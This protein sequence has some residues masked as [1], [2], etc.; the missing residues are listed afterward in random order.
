MNDD[1]RLRERFAF[2]RR[3]EAASTPSFERVLGRARRRTHDA[4]WKVGVA[5]ALVMLT[6]TVI[7]VRMTPPRE[8]PT[9][10]ASHLMLADWRAATDFLLDTPGRELLHTIPDVGR[11]FSTGL[12]PLPPTRM[13]T[14]APRAGREHS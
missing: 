1:S 14:P 9:I 8:S 11:N 2:L 6:V 5:A 13:T 4:L 10:P 12:G 7:T 3:A